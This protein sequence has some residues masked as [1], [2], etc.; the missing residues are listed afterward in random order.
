MILGFCYEE[1]ENC[2]LLGHHAASCGNYQYSPCNDPEERSSQ[3]SY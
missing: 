3:Y 1:D 2:A